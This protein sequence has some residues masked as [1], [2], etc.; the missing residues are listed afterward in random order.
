VAMA[1]RAAIPAIT[2]NDLKKGLL[3]G[4]PFHLG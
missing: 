4:A 2:A 1:V 3:A